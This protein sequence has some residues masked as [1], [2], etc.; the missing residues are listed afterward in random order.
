MPR[1]N[2][3]NDSDRARKP[4]PLG[5]K[6]AM[7]RANNPYLSSIRL[8]SRLQ[9]RGNLFG[10]LRCQCRGRLC[11]VPLQGQIKGRMR[12][13]MVLRVC[14]CEGGVLARYAQARWTDSISNKCHCACRAMM[15]LP[16]NRGNVRIAPT[17]PTRSDVI[18]G[19]E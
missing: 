4:W 2:R 5:H 6:P 8:L 7:R 11:I 13:G 17:P 19:R 14:A 9:A 12:T 15:G 3:N 16:W 1:V 18:R 10:S